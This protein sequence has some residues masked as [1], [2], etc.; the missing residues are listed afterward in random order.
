MNK[1]VNKRK[2]KLFASD[3]AIAVA[4]TNFSYG[5]LDIEKM[6]LHITK[7]LIDSKREACELLIKGQLQMIALFVEALKNND[8]AGSSK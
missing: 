3:V 2:R 7:K 5:V 4:I 8:F 1:S 6:K